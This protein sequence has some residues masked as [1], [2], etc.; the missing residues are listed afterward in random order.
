M[1]GRDDYVGPITKSAEAMFAR[2]ERRAGTSP[3]KATGRSPSRPKSAVHQ[4]LEK[5]GL[6]LTVLRGWEDAGIVAFQRANGRRLLDDDI[7]ECLAAVISLRRAGFTIRQ[8]AWISDTLPP[9][10]AAMRQAL[11]MRESQITAARNSTIA[12]V[13]VAGCASARLLAR[14]ERQAP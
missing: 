5:L 4:A 7:L 6:S 12:R 14:L 13:L 9:S 1:T 2:A 10:A 8:I 3:G 11:Q